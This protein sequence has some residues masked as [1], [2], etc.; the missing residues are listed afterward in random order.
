MVRPSWFIS[1][2]L[3][4]TILN[5]YRGDED[6]EA[7]AAISSFTGV[8]AFDLTNTLKWPFGQTLCLD[9]SNTTEALHP[10]KVLDAVAVD[11]WRDHNEVAVHCAGAI[12][13]VAVLAAICKN[14]TDLSKITVKCTQAGITRYPYLFNTLLPDLG[15]TIDNRDGEF[16]VGDSTMA[17]VDGR[18]GDDWQAEYVRSSLSKAKYLL[19]SGTLDDAID[20][21]ARSFAFKV[22]HVE[23]AR[24]G[25]N[26]FVNNCDINITDA[27]S[28][29]VAL[30]RYCC[31]QYNSLNGVI[32]ESDTLNA[33]NLRTSFYDSP[34]FT[35]ASKYIA[36]RG[37][38]E[39]G[40]DSL[41]LRQY[42]LD[43]FGDQEWF[44]SE[45]PS[46]AFYVLAR[47]KHRTHWLD[48]E[49]DAHLYSTLAEPTVKATWVQIEYWRDI[50]E[51]S[52]IETSLGWFHADPH[53][54]EN[55]MLGAITQF[56]SLETLN[57]DGTLTW[58][59][60]WQQYRNMTQA[61]LQQAYDEIKPGVAIRSG[62]LHVK[63][64]V[65]EAVLPT[66]TITQLKDISFWFT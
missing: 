63:A 56:N 52:P 12:D 40:N 10:H 41:E 25:I 45:R 44:D 55:R 14:S 65:F 21:V 13:D 42:C 58:K 50:H 62:H 59:Q 27:W 32:A 20:L 8:T 1:T 36:S 9:Y 24:K 3:E 47:G 6:F 43:Y 7:L 19:E 17:Y 64:A 5:K 29:F 23:S 31:T 54:L 15:I 38:L 51:V 16:L 22:E 48:G 18:S 53:S 57:A 66:P 61:E 49:G 26:R 33:F 28:F 35:A 46:V 2:A 37:P 30:Y 34:K 4:S 60:A 39:E 11:V